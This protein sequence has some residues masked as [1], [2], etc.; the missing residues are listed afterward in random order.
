[1]ERNGRN[2]SD[3]LVRGTVEELQSDRR[4]GVRLERGG[5]GAI[6]VEG[7]VRRAG[8]DECF[9]MVFGES[10]EKRSGTREGGS[11]RAEAFRRRVS[12][13]VRES[14]TQS[15]SGTEV[16]GLLPS[17]LAPLAE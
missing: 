1:M 4:V 15:S 6:G 9:L 10:S 2:T 5:I 16:K 8:V 13:S 17:F 7:T 11:E 12:F 14:S 3:N